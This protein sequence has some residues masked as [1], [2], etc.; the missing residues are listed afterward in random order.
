MRQGSSERKGTEVRE[1]R[2]TRGSGANGFGGVPRNWFFAL[3]LFVAV[4][5]SAVA[6]EAETGAAASNKSEYSMVSRENAKALVVAAA[7]RT[8]ALNAAAA[9]V[10]YAL[11]VVT[12]FSIL[13]FGP[14]TR[15]ILRQV[16][17]FLAC[18]SP[19]IFLLL[20]YVAR[21]SV[22]H[23]FFVFL[24]VAIYPLVGRPLLVRV[25][26]ASRN[27][28]FIDAK[29]LG[30]SAYGVFRHYA[31]PRFFPLTL[32]YFFLGF[33]Q[34]LLMESMFSSLGLVALTGSRG[35]TWG[36]LI[37]AGLEDL[38]DQPWLVLYSGVAIMTATLAAYLCVPVVDRLLSLERKV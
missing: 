2:L 31:W 1:T 21:Q 24:A 17:D 32:P 25:S 19:M 4:A 14:W 16:L 36:G 34:S 5:A 27:F 18:L 26:E 7:G 3:W 30:H 10:T 8:L 11:A 35:L 29:A 9:A 13:Y 33:I 12:A 20:I 6:A 37:H 22:G 28:H 15:G 38:L 23:F